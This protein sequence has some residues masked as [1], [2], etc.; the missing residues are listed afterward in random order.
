VTTT[1]AVSGDDLHALGP[2]CALVIP[3]KGL[4][5]V[6]VQLGEGIHQVGAQKGVDIRRNK[7]AISGSILGPVRVVTHASTAA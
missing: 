2:V 4:Q 6:P 7:S 3:L 1:A 5:V